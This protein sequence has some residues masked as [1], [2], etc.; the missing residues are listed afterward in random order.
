MVQFVSFEFSSVCL[1]VY[2]VVRLFV[3]VLFLLLFVYFWGVCTCV[4]HGD[5]LSWNV[6]DSLGKY[7]YEEAL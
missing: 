3:S 4:Y 5:V 2:V 6:L 7:L 1:F